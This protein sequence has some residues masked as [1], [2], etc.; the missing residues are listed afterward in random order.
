MSFLSKLAI[1]SLAAFALFRSKKPATSQAAST[2]AEPAVTPRPTTAA[3][4]PRRKSAKRR[5]SAR[6]AKSA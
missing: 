3:A 2:K 4:K 6:P 1:G 5:S